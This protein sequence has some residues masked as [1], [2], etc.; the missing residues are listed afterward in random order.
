[1][2]AIAKDSAKGWTIVAVLF[3]CFGLIAS[4]RG[5]V[6]L[7]MPTWETE[8]G[9]SRSFISAVGAGMLLVVALLGP[10]AGRRVDGALRAPTEASVVAF[11]GVAPPPA[12]TRR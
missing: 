4:A 5:T 1:M 10:I 2:S 9:W 3:L 8:L 7:V 11:R 6:G 12:L